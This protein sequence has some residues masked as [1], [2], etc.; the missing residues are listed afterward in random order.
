VVSVTDK[1][2]D[3]HINGR[4]RSKH[5]LVQEDRIRVGSVELEFSLYDEPVTDD[6]AAKTMAELNSYKAPVSSSRR[7]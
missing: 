4:R 7:S 2:A 3:L 1:D 5:R 6:V